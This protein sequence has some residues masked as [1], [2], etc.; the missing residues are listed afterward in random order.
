VPEFRL[1]PEQAS[2]A[3][4]R[5]DALYFFL[6]AVSLFFIVAIFTALLFFAARYRRR[7]G[8]ERK[9]Y[10]PNDVRLEVAWIV[11][12]LFLALVM[13]AWGAALFHDTS[14]APSD[15]IEVHVIG[16]QWMWKL[17]HPDGPRELNELH[18]PTGRPVKL[19]LASEDVIHSFFIPAFRVKM[20]VVPGRTTTMWFEATKPGTYHLF[21]AEY[22]GTGHSRMVGRVVVLEPRAY[23]EWLSG[24]AGGASPVEQGRRLFERLG[25]GTCHNDQP[26]ARG[27]DLR[28]LY[29][30]RAGFEGGGSA[31]V[32][33][34]YL[35]ESILDPNARVTAKWPPVMPA[36]R[37]QINE[38]GLLA[39][40]AYIKSMERK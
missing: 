33:D 7:P 29:G 11:V 27:P 1:F 21:C 39:L 31:V 18:V 37:G 19:V 20:D 34:N 24:M 26:G 15:A 4:G 2:T 13:F 28:G 36:Y 32:D 10:I 12:P 25:C 6:I 22:C 23:Q 38:E 8:V 30:S 3:A 9:P 35:R 16:K 40:I 14:R 17:Q 5:V